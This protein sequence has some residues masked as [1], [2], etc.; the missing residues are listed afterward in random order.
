MDI[1][2]TSLGVKEYIATEVTTYNKS[3]AA[4]QVRQAR[5]PLDQ[6]K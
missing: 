4:E 1:L 3:G 2:H 5:W 6:A